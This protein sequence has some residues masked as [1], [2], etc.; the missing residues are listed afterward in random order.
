MPRSNPDDAE[1]GVRLGPMREEDVDQVLPIEEASFASPWRREHFH[2]ELAENPFAVTRVLRR[3]DRVIGYAAL[4]IVGRE[5][6]INNLAVHADERRRGLADQMLRR[7]LDL[8]RRRGCDEATLEVRTSN[9]PARAL[10]RK[11][12]FLEV[13]TRRNYYALE[14]EDAILM[15][16]ELR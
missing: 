4:W 6:R 3:G 16:L 13:G 8:G 5:L 11:H 10:Y 1:P 9:V 7:L 15:K 12:G 2:H 14:G